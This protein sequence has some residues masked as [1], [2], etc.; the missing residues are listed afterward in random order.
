MV[1]IGVD[2]HRTQHSAVALDSD[3]R[4]LGQHCLPN[5]PKGFASLADWAAQFPQPRGYGFAGIA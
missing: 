5:H 4:I 2:P 3:G 1:I